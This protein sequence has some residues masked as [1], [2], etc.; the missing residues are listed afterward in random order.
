M[1]IQYGGSVYAANAASL[2]SQPNVDGTLVGGASLK[3]DAFSLIVK[4]ALEAKAVRVVPLWKRGFVDLGFVARLIQ[5][6]RRERIDLLHTHLW[7]ANLWGRIAAWWTGRPVIVTEHS[8]DAWKPAYYFWFDR[9]LARHTQRLIAVSDAVKDFYVSRGIPPPLCQTIPNGIDTAQFLAPQ[10]SVI[11]DELQWP[12]GTPVFV[13]A[14]RLVEAKNL[15]LFVDA[16]AE[17]I[18][19]RPQARGLIVGDGPL[20]ASIERHIEEKGL[21]GR[22]VLTGARTDIPA[23]FHG[24]RAVVFTSNREGLPMVL[25]EAMAS[26]VPVVS[27]AVGGIPEVLQEGITGFLV[28]PGSC[29][30]LAERLK[31]LVD[32]PALAQQ[33]GRAARQDAQRRFSVD[34][35]MRRHQELYDEVLAAP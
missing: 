14:G 25:I 18:V 9:W 15:G 28:A 7:G 5:L 24:A 33:L 17:L 26:G 22:V 16:M 6:I 19:Q 32:D 23:V 2:L 3:A 10:H 21:K 11:F 1:R 27:T 29:Q 31:R 20:R 4:A 35:M 34:V 12:P 13:A 30:P 8:T